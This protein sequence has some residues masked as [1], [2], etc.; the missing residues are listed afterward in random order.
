MGESTPKYSRPEILSRRP[1]RTL[2]GTL[3]IVATPI[4]NLGDMTFRAVETL[5][6]VS[7]IAAEDTRHSS[8][9][10]REFGIATHMISYH[11]HN[12]A[13][14]EGRILRELETGD[15]ALISDAGTP[16]IAD[17]GVEIAALAF[18]A[19][20]T[21]VPV[22]GASALTAAVSASGLVPGPFLFLGFLPRSGEER[23]IAIGKAA[24]AGV[25][26]VVYEAPTRLLATLADIQAATGNRRAMVGRELT[27]LHEELRTG[28]LEV[29][30][31]HFGAAPPRGEFV[32]VV[33]GS[34]DPTNGVEEG[35]V[36]TIIR[37]LLA[38][39]AKPSRAARDAAAISGIS[40]A[41]AYDLVRRITR[42][43]TGAPE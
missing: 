21:V 37:Q 41:D 20:H 10:L 35:D 32:I 26:F 17:P 22:P 43:G 16:G 31:V 14:R 19:G 8:I 1:R 27:K 23:R 12:L 4:G 24:A 36:E 33:G 13:S 25:P 15:V 5:R 34:A 40:G 7:L 11:Q 42:E 28:T 29:L 39:G 6:N 2:V 30:R 9:L 38:D 18:E 3:F